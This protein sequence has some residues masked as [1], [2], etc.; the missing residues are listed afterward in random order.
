MTLILNICI[1]SAPIIFT[2]FQL[3]TIQS[4]NINQD[5]ILRACINVKYR[6]RY[7]DTV[8]ETQ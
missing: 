1:C 2:T 3:I 6:V 7:S 8:V 5:M 4:D